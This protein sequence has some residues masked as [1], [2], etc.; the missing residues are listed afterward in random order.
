MYKLHKKSVFFSTSKNRKKRRPCP[1]SGL[2]NRLFMVKY[3]IIF[4]LTFNFRV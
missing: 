2:Q 1:F 4:R 3:V